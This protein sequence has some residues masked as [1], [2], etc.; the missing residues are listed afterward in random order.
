MAGNQPWVVDVTEANFQSA[1]IDASMERPVVVD[2]WSSQCPPCRVLGPILEKVIGERE[3]AVILAKVNTDQ[4]YRLADA[5]QIESIPAIRA[6]R[7]GQ[8][9]SGFDGAL[10]EKAVRA[11]LDEITQGEAAPGAQPAVEADPAEAERTYRAD[12]A[13][14]ADDVKARLGLAR[15]LLAQ[16]KLDQI[17]E[18][19][20]PVGASGDEGAEA[21]RIG[22]ELYFRR[23]AKTLPDEAALRK[24]AAADPKAAQPLYQLGCRLAAKGD[25]AGALANLYAAAERDFALAQGKGR[26]AMVKVFYA[27]GPNHALANE[28][29][30]K[31]ARLLY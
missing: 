19:L 23:L 13:A 15:A 26:E 30:T 2:F 7:N 28:Y 31:L 17:E 10:P 22:A 5:F 1:V 6:V 14:N 20:A 9:V 25:F 21:E 16:D 8:I 24:Q 11:F 18:V 4:A 12:L 29:R 27:V 3:G